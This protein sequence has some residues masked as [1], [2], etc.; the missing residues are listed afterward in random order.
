MFLHSAF[1]NKSFSPKSWKFGSETLSSAN[2]GYGYS[3]EN[4]NTLRI[5]SASGIR[6]ELDATERA[7]Q[8]ETI[9][10]YIEHCDRTAQTNY[11]RQS[12]NGPTRNR[13]RNA[14]RH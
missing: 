10:L 1:S 9:R 14:T 2:D 4:N 12:A 5:I 6:P 7:M 8:A 3:R 13:Q 11:V